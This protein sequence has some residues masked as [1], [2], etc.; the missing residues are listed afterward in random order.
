MQDRIV[1]FVLCG[2]AGSRLWPLS[3]EDNPKQFHDFSGRGSMLAQTLRRLRARPGG[4]TPVFPIAAERHA[5]RLH[6]EPATT[7]L[8]GGQIIFEPVGRNTAAA[9]AVATR[10]TL[11]TFG[12]DLVLIVPS[13]HEILTE[14]QFWQ[15]VEAGATAAEAGH[16]VVFG[17]RPTKAETGYGYIEAG[18]AIIAP[19]TRSVR[20]FVEKPDRATA[21]AYVEAGNFFWNAG[22]FLF[23]ASSMRDAFLAFAPEIWR[24]AEAA[25]VSATSDPAGLHLP[26][27]AYAKI[28]SISIDYAVMERA[29]PI[30]MVPAAFRWNDLGS[31][32]SLL[33]SGDADGDGN[34]VVGD[35]VSIECERSYLR[36]SGQ[37]LA[38]IGMKDVTIV[39]T[40]D[41]TFIAP[42]ARSQDV[43]SIVERLRRDGRPETM[44]TPSEDSAVPP[45]AW[46]RRVA[47][48]LFDEALPLWSEAGVDR[49]HGGFFEA[50][51]FDGSPLSRQ[52]RMRTMA[53]QVFA[54]AVAKQ[55][56]WDGPA[57]ALID[58][59]IRFMTEKGRTRRGGFARALD[60][61]GAV[62]D[63]AE[64]AYDHACVL[65]ALAHAHIAGHPDA[66]RLGEETMAFLDERLDDGRFTGFHETCD[67]GGSR[68]SN[69]HM[70]LLEAF[71]AWHEAT[72]E[73]SFLRRAAGIVDLFRNHFFDAESWT[74]GEFFDDDWKPARGTEGDW[75]EPGH[76]F[77]W[78]ALLVDFANRS[79]QRDL[80]SFARKLYAS[81][82]AAGLNRATGLAYGAVSRKGLPLD[83]LSRSW[84]QAEAIKA[85]IALDGADGPDL[86]PEIE[87]RVARLFRWHIDPA[88]KG[89]WVDRIDDKGR[90]VAAD[91][92]AS[93]LYHLVFALTRYL[94]FADAQTPRAAGPDA[95]RYAGET[96]GNGRPAGGL[97]R[98]R[99]MPFAM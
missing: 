48:W 36:S 34:V 6:G 21:H 15:S 62:A 64:D 19:S 78:A 39:S 28:P 41:V 17:I 43:K 44:V 11:E 85:V 87:A 73:R 58:H 13:D 40:P 46:R 53:R 80:V 89:L 68:R 76:H 31:W 79:G 23:R 22:I 26:L 16:L 7:D 65:L 66:L 50:L 81:A 97:S 42:V 57:D 67:G 75:T 82:V 52:K 83:G 84:P 35:V 38:A 98:K 88:P 74:L 56:G 94:D 3:R 72:G 24:G 63:P 47:G 55:Y 25:L 61:E 37:L 45:G 10:H 91:V 49:R 70:H 27:D 1:S 54:F 32:Q 60:A 95:D 29:D 92:P 4:A 86:K 5:D 20:R 77:E 8:A 99:G 90:A 2:G 9:A 14:G 96:A 12:D 93:I 59:G 33:E 30:A 51:A 18:E 71:L 69:P